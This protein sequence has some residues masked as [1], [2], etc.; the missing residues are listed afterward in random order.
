[1]NDRVILETMRS[2]NSIDH[3]QVL[4]IAEAIADVKAIG[5]RLF[6]AGCG[7]GAAHASHAAADFRN[8]CGL[9]SYCISDNTAALTAATN[10]HGW[11]SSYFGYM[12]ASHFQRYDGL[13]LISVGGGNRDHNLSIN[14]I[15]AAHYARQCCGTILG[16]FG[17]DGGE[18]KLLSDHYV[19][20]PCDR[21]AFVTP[22]TEGVQSVVLHALAV[23]PL[24]SETQ[25]AWETATKESLHGNE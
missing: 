16:I 17:R 10:D 2:L 11:N 24:L 22:V 21:P 4:A 12:K 14:L 8:L 9:E 7:G 15:E 25:P 18:C 19:L 20:I 23:H 1:M 6:T 5:G 13:L 3:S